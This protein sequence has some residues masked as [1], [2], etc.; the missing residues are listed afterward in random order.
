MGKVIAANLSLGIVLDNSFDFTS[1][2]WAIWIFSGIIWLP[3][4]LQWF[5]E[6]DRE[7][8]EAA[9]RKSLRMVKA[10]LIPLMIWVIASVLL[11]LRV[12]Q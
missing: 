7:D 12:S 3:L 6:F 5:L 4:F 9:I 2:I 1:L 11:L 10:F 8:D